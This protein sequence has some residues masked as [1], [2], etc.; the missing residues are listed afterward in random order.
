MMERQFHFRYD[1]MLRN[2]RKT[3]TKKTATQ[4]VIDRNSCKKTETRVIGVRGAAMTSTRVLAPP[5]DHRTRCATAGG[6]A[7]AAIGDGGNAAF[8]RKN[9]RY[10]PNEPGSSRREK[11]HANALLRAVFGGPR[12]SGY[13]YP[14][15]RYRI[16]AAF[17]GCIVV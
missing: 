13:H 3:E 6:P 2:R 11:N 10:E 9:S 7:T 4:N 8:F 12:A 1:T 17:K 16:G 5:H 15:I 14:T